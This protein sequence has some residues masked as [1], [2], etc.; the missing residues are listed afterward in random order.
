MSL[1]CGLEFL[2]V[3]IPSKGDSTLIPDFGLFG[4]GTG[5]VKSF[6]EKKAET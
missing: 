3:L 4:G 2:L 6:I 1:C 5:C